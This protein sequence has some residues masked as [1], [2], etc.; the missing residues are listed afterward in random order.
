MNEYTCRVSVCDDGWHELCRIDVPGDA[1]LFDAV[2]AMV[3]GD[4]YINHCGVIIL[5]EDITPAG[6]GMSI[7]LLNHVR[8]E[9]V[10][11]IDYSLIFDNTDSDEDVM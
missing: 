10:S 7:Y 6:L 3:A 8:I 4:Y 9:Y 5:D 2:H 1:S 11:T